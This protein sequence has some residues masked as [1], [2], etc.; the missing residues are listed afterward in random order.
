MVMT[1]PSPVAGTELESVPD[2]PAPPKERSMVL[3]DDAPAMLE[4]MA[5][6]PLVIVRVTPV[7]LGML[8]VM[9]TEL[10]LW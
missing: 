9:K 7:T 4:A 5:T 10:V 6:E 8:P 2:L 1:G 3:L